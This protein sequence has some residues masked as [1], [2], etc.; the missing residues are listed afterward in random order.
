LSATVYFVDF[1]GGADV[2]DGLSTLTPWQHCPGDP[3]AASNP[4]RLTLQPGDT[5]NFKGGVKYRGQI[6]LQA[7]GTATARIVFQGQP[8]G[9]GS[10]KAIID[11]T[12]PL[13]MTVC[14]GQGTGS[15]QVPNPNFASIWQGPLPAGADWRL[16]VF[17]SDVWLDLAQAPS[18][19]PV[20]FFFDDTEYFTPL[21]GGITGTTCRDPARFTQSDPTYWVGARLL[22]HVSGNSI[23]DAAITGYDP[24]TQTVTYPSLG[25][26]MADSNWDS[27]YHYTVVN[28]P[29]LPTGPGSTRSM[30]PAPAFTCGRGPTRPALRSAR[31]PSASA[32]TVLRTSPSMASS[33][34]ASSPPDSFRAAR[35][36]VR[37]RRPP[38][39]S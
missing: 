9:W 14:T 10:G 16:P 19:N 18:A 5:V 35:S 36:M 30:W 34:R 29:R 31:S 27:K 32:P 1:A 17:E 38:T 13:T 37:R 20:P 12:A 6:T 21:A 11:G 15:G 23:G 4:A 22:A 8:T 33:S 2:N 28:S 7:S 25:T 39:G 3:A 26:P 24:A